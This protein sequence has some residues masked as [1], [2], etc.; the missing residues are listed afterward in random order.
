M[1]AFIRGVVSAVDGDTIIIDKGGIGLEVCVPISMLKPL[2][3]VGDELTLYTHLQVKEDGWQLFG[4]DD[5]D[6]LQT[7]ITQ[8]QGCQESSSH[9]EG[10]SKLSNQCP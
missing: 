4:F 1:I 5:K 10:K 7:R 3:A 6:I 8:C 2:P 9:Q